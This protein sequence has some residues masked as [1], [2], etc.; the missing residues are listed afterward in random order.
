M[1]PC[2]GLADLPVST[3]SGS[4]QTLAAGRVNCFQL[5][6]SSLLLNQPGG[7]ARHRLL[8]ERV[9]WRVKTAQRM[10]AED[11]GAESKG[12]GQTTFVMGEGQPREEWRGGG[13]RSG[14]PAQAWPGS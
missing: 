7:V 2:L 12:H 11:L 8:L 9:G 1:T 10:A 4:P 3:K 14:V 13:G 5:F 6:S